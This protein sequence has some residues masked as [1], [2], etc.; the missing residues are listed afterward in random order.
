MIHS[1]GTQIAVGPYW[2]TVCCKKKTNLQVIKLLQTNWQW[3]WGFGAPKGLSK[4]LYSIDLRLT[5]FI[6]F[7]PKPE[8]WK[9][10]GAFL[11]RFSGYVQMVDHR[12]DPKHTWEIIYLIWFGNALGS[13]RKRSCCLLEGRL[14]YL[15]C[16]HYPASTLDKWQKMDGWII[17][18][19][20][21]T[22]FKI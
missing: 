8:C 9:G 13:L 7:L 12:V 6:H 14:D 20:S 22:S 15:C 18:V 21:Q 1:L 5:A 3:I 4:L 16:H 19:L 11:L 10:A 2:A 17:P